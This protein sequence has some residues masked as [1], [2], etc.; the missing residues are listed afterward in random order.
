VLSM[1]QP[2]ETIAV[3]YEQIE[4]NISALV[5]NQR[6]VINSFLIR[7]IYSSSLD[8]SKFLSVDSA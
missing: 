6:A 4:T 8:S 1:L 5:R 3:Y 2:R 7:R